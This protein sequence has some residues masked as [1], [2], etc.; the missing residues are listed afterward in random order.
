MNIV[1]DSSPLALLSDPK[2]S[3]EV[4]ADYELRRELFR[5]GTSRAVGQKLSSGFTVV[6]K[7]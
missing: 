7:T 2:V 3:V 4:I 6:V 5:T 1:L